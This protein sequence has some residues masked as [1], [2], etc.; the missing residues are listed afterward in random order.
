MISKIATK[1]FDAIIVG[2]GGSGLRAALQMAQSDYKVAV[3]SKV[4]P[5]RSHTVSAQGGIAAP[6]GNVM[7]DKWE[8]HMYDTVMGSDCLSDQA[9][10]E[11]MCMNASKAVIELEHM[12]MPFSRLDNGKIYQRP[13]G[14]HTTNF[15][16]KLASRTC[17]AADRTGHAMLH[18]LFQA[19]VKAETH[20]F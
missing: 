17:A 1:E 3:I 10:V 12:G 4:Y 14:G 13:F 5:T 15:G 2:A 8:Y 18:T 19:N 16:E 7:E 9:A 20:F 6:L 11:Y